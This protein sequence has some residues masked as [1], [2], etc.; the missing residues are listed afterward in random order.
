MKIYSG[1]EKQ[2]LI[3]FGKQDTYR[4][5]TRRILLSK[6]RHN[7]PETIRS[8]TVDYG[9]RG[10]TNEK[11]NELQKPWKLPIDRNSKRTILR[12]D[13]GIG[14]PSLAKLSKDGCHN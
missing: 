8:C 10:K 7:F 14:P 3:S 11:E 9:T 6:R 2:L 4:E 13:T 12:S 5:G 1:I